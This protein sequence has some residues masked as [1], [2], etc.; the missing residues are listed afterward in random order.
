M[1]ENYT[2]QILNLFFTHTYPSATEEKVKEWIANNASTTEVDRT[3]FAVWNAIELRPNKETHRA[4]QKVKDTIGLSKPD[5]RQTLWNRI[6]FKSVAAI[7]PLCI[8]IATYLYFRPE[9]SMIE[10]V[11]EA[12]EQKQCQLPDGTTIRLNS[13]SKITY[14][15]VFKENT[16]LVLLEGEAYFSVVSDPEKP[17]IVSTDYFSVKVLGTQFNVSAYPTDERATTTL[18][19]G[20]VEVKLKEGAP[21]SPYTLQPSQQLIYNKNDHSVSLHKIDNAS[22]DWKDGQLIFRDASFQDII[23]TLQRRFNVTIDYD[24][25]YFPNLPYTVKFVQGED[26]EDILN[27]MQAMIGEFNYSIRDNV[28]KLTRTTSTK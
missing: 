9:V 19:K 25:Q 13:C 10:V 18:S 8:L 23:Q 17:F 21:G 26:L 5:T 2:R 16:R 28:V 24:K 4:L 20:R 27:I 15:S 6:W 7:I 14:P 3:L 12:N 22:A 1:K 11:T